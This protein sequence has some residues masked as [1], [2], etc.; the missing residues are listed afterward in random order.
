MY[1]FNIAL[2]LSPPLFTQDVNLFGS[3]MTDGQIAKY[4]NLH[5]GTKIIIIISFD[6]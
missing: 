6:N 3:E 1:S 5:N 4:A 2:S